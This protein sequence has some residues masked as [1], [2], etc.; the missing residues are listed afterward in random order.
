MIIPATGFILLKNAKGDRKTTSVSLCLLRS[1]TLSLLA[2]GSIAHAYNFIPESHEWAAWPSYCK[3]R[4][5]TT[6]VG[7]SSP[8]ANG[9]SRT[10]VAHWKAAIGDKAFL[11]VHHYCAGLIY[12]QRAQTGWKKQPR[13]YLLDQALDEA[14]Y[15][16]RNVG[17]TNHM[18]SHFASTMAAVLMEKGEQRL[19]LALVN[20]VI[21]KQPHSEQAY[22]VGA[23]VFHRA[24]ELEQAYSIVQ[25]G[26][27]R[28]DSPSA[29]FFYVYGLILFDLN[30]YQRAE[31][32]AKRAYALGYPLP[33]L[34][35]KLK[36]RGLF[37]ED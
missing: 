26:E 3:A 6:D 10:E 31:S 28:I 33:G 25:N 30:H 16:Y 8:F 32:Y 5:V 29:E 17:P 27:S 37:K 24:G 20:E 2:I 23:I 21:E 35:N 4:Y 12:L 11:H 1:V 34:K 15:A 9:V 18:A 36:Q 13:G 22:V 7:N 14:T 19:A